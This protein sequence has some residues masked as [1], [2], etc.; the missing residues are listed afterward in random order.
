MEEIE[1]R[2]QERNYET[3]SMR[4]V[5]ALQPSSLYT[6]AAN[7]FLSIQHH[8]LRLWHRPY[9]KKACAVN[10]AAPERG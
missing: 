1:F 10:L 7:I 2:Q 4:R 3:L 5:Y 8:Y 6:T 9:V